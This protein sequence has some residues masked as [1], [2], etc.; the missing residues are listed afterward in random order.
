MSRGGGGSCATSD[1]PCSTTPAKLTAFFNDPANINNR[2]AQ[3]RAYDP[4]FTI[5]ERIYQYTASW[6]QQWGYKM[7][8]TIAYVGSQGRDLFLRNVANRI[9]S[10]RNNTVN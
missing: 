2:Q 4:N 9:L 7:V 8:S 5:P 1:P 10:G 6:Q 3:V